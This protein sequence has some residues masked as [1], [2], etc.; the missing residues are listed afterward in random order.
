MSQ[1]NH[2]PKPQLPKLY[3]FV[4]LFLSSLKESVEATVSVRRAPVSVL[5]RCYA[6]SHLALRLGRVHITNRA[7]DTLPARED[8]LDRKVI[9]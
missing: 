5:T 2:N 9:L 7:H 4:F 3:I 1:V 6:L 8:G